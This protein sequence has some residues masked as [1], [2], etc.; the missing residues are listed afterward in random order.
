M[1]RDLFKP[2]R[3]QQNRMIGR[4]LKA[5]SLFSSAGIGD[6]GVQ[7]AGIQIV[8]ANELLP[9]RVALYRENFEH[10]ILE[11]DVLQL[12]KQLIESTVRALQGDELF[13]LH[14]TPPCQGMS[15]NGMGKLK[16]EIASGR[17]HEED[18]RNRLIIPTMDIAVALKP[19]WLLLENVP[20]MERTTI[21]TSGSHIANIIDYV[22]RRLGTDYVGAPQVIACEDFGI[23]QRRKRL[24]TIF[25]RD[26]GGKQYFEKNGNSFFSQSMQE[27]RRTLRDAIAHSP[28]LDAIPGANEARFFHPYHYVPV[29]SERKRTW[30]R[31]TKEGDTAF[32]NQCIN[33][34]CLCQDNPGHVDVKIKGKWVSSKEIPIYCLKCGEL[35]PRPHVVEG[36]GPRLLRGF[37][38]AYRRMKWDEPA[39]TLTQ[40]FIYEASDNK[41]HPTQDRVLSIYEAMVLQTI[42]RYDYQFCAGGV[43]ISPAK[44]AEVIGESV[45]P[46]LFQKICMMMLGCSSSDS[47][48]PSFTKLMDL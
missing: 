19:R 34:Q 2:L 45:P 40:N 14:A 30:V 18:A 17:R 23:P 29:I 11:G 7:A 41:I 13:L 28:A 25:T 26:P 46:Y 32:N 35:L 44:I 39:R 27:P 48:G 12:K 4:S 10:E 5:V 3:E 6:L 20:G 22:K 47:A 43:D 37:H 16:A 1:R 36:D 33:P 9:S 8:L 31:H 38:S 21:R 42:S 15:S 24:I